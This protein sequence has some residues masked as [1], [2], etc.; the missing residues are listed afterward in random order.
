MNQKILD[1]I[2]T[3]NLEY[4]ES[5]VSPAKINEVIASFV[6][7][8]LKERPYGP[9]A[10][11]KCPDQFDK[12]HLLEKTLDSVEKMDIVDFAIARQENVKHFNSF[13]NKYS[14]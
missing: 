4:W 7:K 11:L 6:M 1:K 3:S 2:T 14:E 5:N 13:V 8:Q 10:V 12:Y 9:Y